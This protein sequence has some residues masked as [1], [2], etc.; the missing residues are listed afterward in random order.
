MTTLGGTDHPMFCRLQMGTSVYVELKEVTSNKVK[1]CQL[2][3]QHIVGYSPYSGRVDHGYE[4]LE[5][6]WLHKERTPSSQAQRS[7]ALQPRG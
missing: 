6:G 4:S 7:L 1:S 2:L 5:L 3:Q